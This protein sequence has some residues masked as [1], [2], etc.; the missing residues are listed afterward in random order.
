[1]SNLKILVV[2]L[3]LASFS[4]T[5][6]ATSSARRLSLLPRASTLVPSSTAAR[7][8]PSPLATFFPSLSALRVLSSATSRRK[9]VTVVH[10]LAHLA[11]TLLSSATHP[12]RT[13]PASVS[14]VV[15]RKPSLAVLVRLLVSSLVVDVST[16]LCSRLAVRTSNTRPSAT[17]V[18]SSC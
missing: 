6:T 14:L 13:R 15:P 8:L 18:F 2:L 17:S 10:S 5:P 11:T 9:L 3:S 16:S 1:M 4:V 12:M 7:R